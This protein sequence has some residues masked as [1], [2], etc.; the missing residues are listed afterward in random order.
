M[1]GQEVKLAQGQVRK[2][3]LLEG[4]LEASD[5]TQILRHR[6]RGGS[7][8]CWAVQ[9]PRVPVQLGSRPGDN[10]GSPALGIK[11]LQ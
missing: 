9:E 7:G 10:W 4:L 3:R 6:L 8:L 2:P 1:V 11:L 5:G